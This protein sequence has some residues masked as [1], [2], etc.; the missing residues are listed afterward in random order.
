MRVGLLRE[1]TY[2]ITFTPTSAEDVN[3]SPLT[4]KMTHS[5]PDGGVN[6]IETDIQLTVT[7]SDTTCDMLGP[8]SMTSQI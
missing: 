4:Y 6:T 3:N 5:D 2:K 8:E 1:S 7:I